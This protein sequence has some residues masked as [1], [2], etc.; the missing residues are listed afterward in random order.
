MTVSELF[1]GVIGFCMVLYWLFKLAYRAF[2]YLFPHKMG[3]SYFQDTLAAWC[4]AQKELSR[5]GQATG[6]R[7]NIEEIA[8]AH[9]RAFDS[10]SLRLAYRELLQRAIQ[11]EEEIRE[12]NARL[13]Y[14]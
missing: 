5:L 6:A 11:R 10:Q 4:T 7:W 9:K 3:W 14:H 1:L 8:E 2:G 13:G 12:H